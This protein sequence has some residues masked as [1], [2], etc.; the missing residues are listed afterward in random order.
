MEDTLH[1]D[2]QQLRNDVI[3]TTE[4]VEQILEGV[5]EQEIVLTT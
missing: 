2:L 3:E 4:W 1:Q 5:N